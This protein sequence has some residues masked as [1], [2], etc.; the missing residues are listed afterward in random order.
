[1]DGHLD[2]Y[3][4]IANYPWDIIFV[5]SIFTTCGYGLATISKANYVILHSTS[6]EEPHSFSKGYGRLP[7]CLFTKIFNSCP[8]Y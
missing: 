2:E 4:R 1:M 5:D 7:A 8:N 3:L 6:V